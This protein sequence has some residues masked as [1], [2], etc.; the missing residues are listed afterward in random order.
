MF[1]TIVGK[2]VAATKSGAAGRSQ[3]TGNPRGARNLSSSKTNENGGGKTANLVKAGN[4]C[5]SKDSS[6]NGWSFSDVLEDDEQKDQSAG[7]T[8]LFCVHMYVHH[9]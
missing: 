6:T 3:A 9:H 7:K 8:K 2:C 4:F 5:D 1:V